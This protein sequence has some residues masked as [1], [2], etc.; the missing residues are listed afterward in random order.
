MEKKFLSKN[1]KIVMK[2]DSSYLTPATPGMKTYTKIHDE[3]GEVN[4]KALDD[5]ATKLKDYYGEELEAFDAPKVTG[6]DEVG[7]DG[8]DVF[9]IEAL[10]SGKMSALEYEGKGSEVEKKFQKMR[11]MF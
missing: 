9:D 6:K 3:D 10:G 2:E 5:I 4:T 11:R 8:V 7:E 1:T